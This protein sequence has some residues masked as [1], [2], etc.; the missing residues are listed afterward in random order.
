MNTETSQSSRTTNMV[1]TKCNL[2][3][4]PILLITDYVPPSP[5]NIDHIPPIAY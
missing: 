5:S 1:Q 2:I 4:T 3:Y